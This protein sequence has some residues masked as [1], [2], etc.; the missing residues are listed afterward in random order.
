M[1]FG[2]FSNRKSVTTAGTAERLSATHIVPAMVIIQ[3]ETDNR[4]L[5]AIGGSNVDVTETLQE[6]IQLYVGEIMPPLYDIDLYDV[7]VDSAISDDGVIFSY[8]S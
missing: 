4:G 2:L 3:A 6:G 7:W 5:V 8:E 1:A